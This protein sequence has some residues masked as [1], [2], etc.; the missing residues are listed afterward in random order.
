MDHGGGTSPQTCWRNEVSQRG[1]GPAQLRR[2]RPAG[3]C[4]RPGLSPGRCDGPPTVAGRRRDDRHS[5]PLL[6]RDSY[7]QSGRRHRL[8]TTPTADIQLSPEVG[9]SLSCFGDGS[10]APFL[11]VDPNT[12]TFGVRPDL[13]A[14]TFLQDCTP[15]ITAQAT[16]RLARQSLQVTSSPSR[17]RPGSSCPRRT[18]S[19]PRTAALPPNCSASSLKELAT[20]S[21]STRAITVPLQARGRQQP[22]PR[23]DQPQPL[24]AKPRPVCQRESATS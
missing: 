14:E 4:G 12:G 16:T 2:G 13:L 21:N 9:Q 5:C 22:A 23:P 1:A 11:D 3:R 10:P 7:R 19:A 18:S 6:R 8:R 24:T 17:P 15:E 20:S